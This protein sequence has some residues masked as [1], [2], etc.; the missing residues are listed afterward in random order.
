M[1]GDDIDRDELDDV[2]GYDIVQEDGT[3]KTIGGKGGKKKAT[4]AAAD[5]DADDQDDEDQDDDEDDEDDQPAP[6]RAEVEKLRRTAAARKAELTK[7]RKELGALRAKNKDDDGD[8]E[9]RTVVEQETRTKRIAGIAALAGEGMSKAQAKLAVKLLDLDDVELDEDG[10]GDFEDA[11]E[12]LR[13]KFP[14]LF[15]KEATTSGGGRVRTPRV[16]TGN[17]GDGGARSTRDPE[18][19]RLLR[20]AGLKV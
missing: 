6:T 12:E 16:A 3:T 14:A 13:E 1:A 15:A 11:I 8:Q 18:T 5:D 7:L 20:E 19:R 2:E 9:D 17:R 4:R 10:D